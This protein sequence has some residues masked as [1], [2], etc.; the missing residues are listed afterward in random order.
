MEKTLTVKEL[1]N[2]IVMR[3]TVTTA[4]GS[5]TKE[6]ARFANSGMGWCALGASGRYLLQYMSFDHVAFDGSRETYDRLVSIGII[7]ALDA[8]VAA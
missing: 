1:K 7:E 2:D 6:I 3:V 5:S 8:K 4:R